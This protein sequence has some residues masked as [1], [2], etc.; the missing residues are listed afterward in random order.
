M[1]TLHTS[2][3]QVSHLYRQILASIRFAHVAQTYVGFA[4]I[5]NH[6]PLLLLPLQQQQ[7]LEHLLQPQQVCVHGA[8]FISEKPILYKYEYRT[9]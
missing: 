7:I 6:L 3:N 2:N 4:M 8:A 1:T 5:F 9:M